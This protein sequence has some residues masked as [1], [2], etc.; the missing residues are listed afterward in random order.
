MTFINNIYAYLNEPYL[1][2]KFLEYDFLPKIIASFQDYD[3][4][5]LV[6]NLFEGNNLNSFKDDIFSE[7]QL[8]FISACIIQSLD[9]LRIEKIISRDVTMNNLVMDKKRY[10]NLIDFSFSIMYSDKNDIKT[11]LVISP[12][13]SSPETNNN[14]LKYDYNSDY[15]RLGVILYYLIFK[16]NINIIKK[17]NNISDILIN[18]NDIKNYSISCID[19]LN[20]LIISDFRKRIGLKSINEL[21]EHYWFKDF[22]WKNFEMKN[23]NS[24][25]KFIINSRSHCENF[26]IS[27][28]KKNL[29]IFNKTVA[30]YN[31]V[32]K[33]IIKKILN[34]KK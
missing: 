5:Y 18:P 27:E 25:L 26:N 21:K 24:P 23:I 31:F 16:K 13:D 11:F 4:F 34:S 9:Y 10:L 8:R 1:L 3:N 20:Q 14:K 29:F 19:F 32:N 12:L 7:E 17:E 30:K 15:Y 6:T 33:I 2:K 22:D 28:K